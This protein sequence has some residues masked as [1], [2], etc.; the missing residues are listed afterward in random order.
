[1]LDLFCRFDMHQITAVD[2]KHLSSFK[3]S[4][5]MTNMI[6]R[7]GKLM[8]K[9]FPGSLESTNKEA[10]RVVKSCLLNLM[11]QCSF[12]E[13]LFDDDRNQMNE[14]QF[15]LYLKVEGVATNGGV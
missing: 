7:I 4:V 13:S 5:P 14:I 2:P 10:K 12:L 3:I 1:M 6:T 8:E 11:H 15:A 9:C